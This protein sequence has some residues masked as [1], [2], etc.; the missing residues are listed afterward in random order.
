[1]IN[2]THMQLQDEQDPEN[3]Y[4]LVRIDFGGGNTSRPIIEL[5]VLEVK[6]L[7]TKLDWAIRRTND[8]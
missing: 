4:D 6:E 7:L 3:P 8:E 2:V 1:M 5:S